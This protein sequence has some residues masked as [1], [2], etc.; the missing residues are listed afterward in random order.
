MFGKMMMVVLA[1]LLLVSMVQVGMTPRVF[2][3]EPATEILTERAVTEVVGEE[4]PGLATLSP[5]GKH[6]AWVMTVGRMRKQE[7]QLCIYTFESASKVCHT[8][9]EGVFNF[10][11]ALAGLPIRRA[12]PLPKTR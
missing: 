9:P 10:L 6:I 12:S 7:L 3:Q 8:L 11:Y 2:A 4:Y 5:D 1:A